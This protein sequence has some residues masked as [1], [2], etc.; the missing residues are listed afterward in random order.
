MNSDTT[1]SVKTLLCLIRHAIKQE[2]PISLPADIMWDDVIS[3]ATKNGLDAIAFDGLQ[4]VYDRLSYLDA[5]RLDKSLGERRY[6]WMGLTLQAEQDYEAYYHKLIELITLLNEEGFQILILKGYG[7][8][9]FYPIPA[10]RPTGDIDMYLFGC[11]KDADAIIVNKLGKG[12]KQNEDKH[13]IFCFKDL[14]VE[15]HAT[16]LNVS[17]HKCLSVIEAFLEQE[18]LSSPTVTMDGAIIHVP[19][20][21]MNA[22]Y[23]P[24]HIASHF[25]FGGIHLKQLTDWAIFVMKQ[26]KIINWD[27]IRKLSLEAG[28]FEFF[29]ALNEII[30]EQFGVQTDCLPDWGFDRGLVDRIWADTLYPRKDLINRNVLEKVIDYFSARW[31][32]R[33]VYRDSMFINFFRHSWASFRGKYLP[34]SRSVWNQ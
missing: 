6:D 9:L 32:Y 31:K 16:F 20:T 19:S 13:S 14:S 3:M 4:G 30:V 33:L 11:G 7:L 15:N 1:P 10:H 18:A 8:S 27:F 23:L 21:T 17:E 34:N 28:F 26:G 12:V 22:I 2:N 25:V 5:A 29:R 24:C